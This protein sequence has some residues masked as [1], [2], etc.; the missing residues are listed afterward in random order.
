MKNILVIVSL[1][2]L[3]I[4][5]QSVIIDD[6][7]L[8]VTEETTEEV[9]VEEPLEIEEPIIEE[10]VEETIEEP[11]EESSTFPNDVQEIFAKSDKV[12][13]YEYTYKDPVNNKFYKI[14]VSGEHMRID[15]VS[16]IYNFYLNTELKT[17]EKYCISYSSCGRETGKIQDLIFDSVFIET[18]VDWMEKITSATLKSES[19]HKGKESVLL[20]TDIGEVIM[21]QNYGFIYNVKVDEKTIHSFS[22]AKFNRVKDED[23]VPPEHLVP[24]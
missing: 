22:E 10:P 6:P 4:G 15:P 19:D 5:C 2:L 20:Y 16:E 3:I 21:D 9:V 17:A 23:V 14:Y 11:V 8:E 12:R 7:V 18:P 1:S 13:N 24:Q